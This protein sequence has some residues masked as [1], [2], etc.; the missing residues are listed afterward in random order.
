MNRFEHVDKHTLSF[1]FV[2]GV[3]AHTK[4]KNLLAEF[5]IVVRCGIPLEGSALL[6]P[7]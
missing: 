7:I 5:A 4:L 1:D 2:K 6:I 3:V